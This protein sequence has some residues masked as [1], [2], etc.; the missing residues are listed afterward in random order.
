MDWG[1]P[2]NWTEIT[3]SCAEYWPTESDA[4]LAI[5]AFAGFLMNLGLVCHF[6]KD[7]KNGT[8]FLEHMATCDAVLIFLYLYMYFG[9]SCIMYNRHDFFGKLHIELQTVVKIFYEF[10]E[11]NL[12]FAMFLIMMER[13]LWTCS[14]RTRFHWTMFTYGKHKYYLVFV[15]ATYILI[16]LGITYFKPMV[17]FPV[18]TQKCLPKFQKFSS[19]PFCDMALKPTLY[20]DAFLRL[21]QDTIFPLVYAYAHIA[22]FILAI[23][24]LFRITRVGEGEKPLDQEEINLANQSGGVPLRLTTGRIKRSIL[25]MLFIYLMFFF[26]AF[27]YYLFVDPQTS[28][29][30]DGDV[31]SGILKYWS[32]D[33]MNVVFSGSRAIVYVVFCRNQ[34]VVEFPPYGLGR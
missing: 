13:F 1:K 5:V 32:Y 31:G 2:L 14:S 19:V 33:F 18:K 16:V 25:C 20:E 30:F 27:C 26:R 10:Y 17:D 3:W 15:T 23:V 8:A 11:M 22:T 6:Y 29:M 9:T 34:M 28:N 4:F 12:T 24:T 7:R 21:L